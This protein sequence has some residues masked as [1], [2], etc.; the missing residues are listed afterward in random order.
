MNSPVKHKINDEKGNLA[1]GDHAVPSMNQ[2]T[3]LIELGLCV[4]MK[5]R[6]FSH[7]SPAQ[8]ISPKELVEKELGRG[9]IG[10]VTHKRSL[11]SNNRGDPD[12]SERAKRRRMNQSRTKSDHGPSASGGDYP[13]TLGLVRSISRKLTSSLLVQLDLIS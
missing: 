9:G 13:N 1:K 3:H 6:N 12:T 10:P 7:L 5:E 2:S 4:A 11:P 8:D